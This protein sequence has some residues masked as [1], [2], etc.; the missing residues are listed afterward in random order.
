M[1]LLFN[2]FLKEG[3]QFVP[4]AQDPTKT[5]VYNFSCGTDVYV[6]AWVYFDDITQTMENAIA[7]NPDKVH[8]MGIVLRKISPI[9]CDF[10]YGGI[11][12]EMFTGLAIGRKFLSDTIAGA[13]QDVT[14]MTSGN[15]NLELGVAFSD[16][17]IAIQVG[18]PLKRV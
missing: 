5:V 18:V 7:N 13:S 4:D 10:I 15:F 6:G 3:F 17:T 1:K 14:V 9:V 8:A 11:T 16:K 2:P 12:P